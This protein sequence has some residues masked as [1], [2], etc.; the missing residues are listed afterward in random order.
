MPLLYSVDIQEMF[1][2]TPSCK[3]QM[4]GFENLLVPHEQRFKA[5]SFINVLIKNMLPF[6]DYVLQ[7]GIVAQ[8]CSTLLKRKN[9][10]TKL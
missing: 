5:H 7:Q 9:C 4:Q 1:L 2:T 10:L 3:P 8:L 6:D